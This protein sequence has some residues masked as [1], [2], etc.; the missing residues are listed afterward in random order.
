MDGDSAAAT[1]DFEQHDYAAAPAP[2]PEPQHEVRRKLYA[3]LPQYHQTD[4]YACLGVDYVASDADIRRTFLRLSRAVHPDRLAGGVDADEREHATAVFATVS[5]AADVLLGDDGA[6]DRLDRVVA[7]ARAEV[8]ACCDG[9]LVGTPAITL[10]ERVT[11]VLLELEWK[12]ECHAAQVRESERDAAADDIVVEVSEQSTTVGKRGRRR[13]RRAHSGSDSSGTF[14]RPKDHRK[15]TRHL[16]V[17]NTGPKF[18][19]SADALKL[20]L[21]RRLGPSSTCA[22]MPAVERVTVVKPTLPFVYVSFAAAE[23]AARCRNALDRRVPGST[24]LAG[25]QCTAEYAVESLPLAPLPAVEADG[26]DLSAAEQLRRL[27]LSM[28]MESAEAESGNISAPDGGAAAAAAERRIVAT[29]VRCPL[30]AGYGGRYQRGRPFRMH[31]L[32]PV[33]QLS[34]SPEDAEAVTTAVRLAEAAADA[35]AAALIAE[36]GNPGA[37]LGSQAGQ[38]GEDHPEGEASTVVEK[39]NEEGMIAA[40]G[41]DLKTLRSLVDAN[42]VRANGGGFD[43]HASTDI[44]GSTALHWAAGGGSLAVVQFLVNECGVD[45]QQ[46]CATGRKD[47]RNAMHW[48]ARNGHTEVCAWLR[49]PVDVHKDD[50]GLSGEAVPAGVDVDACTTDGTVAFHWACWQGQFATCRWLRDVGCNWRKVNDWGCNAAHWAALQG[51][52]PMCR[53][54]RRIGL[55]LTLANN[56]GHTALHKAAYKGHEMLCRWLI[57]N[58]ALGCRQDAEKDNAQVGPTLDNGTQAGC[59]ETSECCIG[60]RRD[61][62]GYTPAMIAREQRHEAL[63]EWLQLKQ[64]ESASR[65]ASTQQCQLQRQE[66]QRLPSEEAGIAKKMQ[67]TGP[68]GKLEEVVSDQRLSD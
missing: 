12:E 50:G 18:G 17:A 21:N 26:T 25:R 32:S 51:N 68:L 27:Q 31:L 67:L 22:S 59:D 38:T 56:Q 46:T 58:T 52:L 11:E 53:W 35:E 7:T 1:S 36:S 66:K 57:A 48:A 43:P 13:A 10:R 40:R 4:A 20:E 47:R 15:P 23:D 28:A 9:A 65:C 24:V 5:A 49:R 19:M 54:L 62:G 3:R 2:E 6:R 61:A 37:A 16:Y 42:G 44:H 8:A 34:D 14:S 29:T 33:H 30:C 60:Y 45:I 41:G 63:A 64:D 39:A 55:D